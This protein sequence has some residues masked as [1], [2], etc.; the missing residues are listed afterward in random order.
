MKQILLT[1]AAKAIQ[2]LE[3]N[4]TTN[5]KVRKKETITLR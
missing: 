3:I 2:Y 1:I 4:L 5:S